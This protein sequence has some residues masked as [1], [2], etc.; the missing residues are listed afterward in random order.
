[1]NEEIAKTP[2]EYYENEEEKMARKRGR[3]DDAEKQ[4]WNGI[5]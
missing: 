1:M 3:W 4:K 5:D 2:K